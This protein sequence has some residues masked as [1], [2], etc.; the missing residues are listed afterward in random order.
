MIYLKHIYPIAYSIYHFKDGHAL[1]NSSCPGLSNVEN[2][3]TVGFDDTNNVYWIPNVGLIKKQFR[4]SKY[5]GKCL[6]STTV[7]TTFDRHEAACT[8]ESIVESKQIAYGP[9][10][11]MGDYAIDAG[12]LPDEFKKYRQRHIVCWDIETLETNTNCDEPGQQAI[13]KPLSIATSTNIPDQQDQFWVR[14]SSAPNDGQQ[15]VDEFLD[16]L[17]RLE[18]SYYETIPHEIRDAL[19]DLDDVDGKFGYDRTQKQKIKFHLQ[20]YLTMCCYAFNGGKLIYYNLFRN[21]GTNS[22]PWYHFIE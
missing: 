2:K 3:I 18:N 7:K 5:P 11:N 16:Y 19:A 6:Y 20:K 1:F 22:V 14:K 21:R 10:Q 17:F 12:I 8:D 9:N 13:L 4:C 15:L